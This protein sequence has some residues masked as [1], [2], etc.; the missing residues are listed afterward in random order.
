VIVDPGM[1]PLPG[2]RTSLLKALEQVTDP[3]ARRG[4]RHSI[5][6]TLAMVVAAGL[7][8]AG[9]SFRAVGDFTADLPQDALARLGARFHPVRRRYIAPNEATIRRHVQMIDADEADAAVGGWLAAL[10]EQARAAAGQAG[11]LTTVAL[12][13]KVLKGAWEEL[14]D[15]KVTLFS[16]LVHGEGVIIGQREVPEGTTEVTQVLPLLDGIAATRYARAGPDGDGDLAGLVFTADALY[17]HRDN[18]QQVTDRGGEYIVTVKSNQPRL[19]R[20]ISALFP[21]SSADRAFPL[22]HVTI[23]RGHG[24]NEIRSI[25][26]SPHVADL[27]FP[28]VFQAFRIHRETYDLNWNPLR[29]PETVHGITSLT[30]WQANP[31]DIL[32]GNRGHWQVEN[33]EHYVRDR[34]FDEDRSQVR[35]K[36]SP[37]FLAT[38]RNTAISLMRLAGCVNI[39]RGLD[40]LSRRLGYVLT[41]FGVLPG[42][43][44]KEVTRTRGL[45]RWP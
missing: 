8:G 14:P 4:I 20:D 26:T 15:V 3:R 16:A 28:G 11:A 12:D 22:H 13:G 29:K 36:A 25:W 23:D 32:T 45:C 38:A 35:T 40:Y 37:Q 19:E 1:L 17:V 6:S 24:R 42:T 10:V 31:A 5:A 9:R 7:S 27:D 41:L 21:A 39:A 2:V 33:R 18:L 43:S 34:T 44:Q 30:A